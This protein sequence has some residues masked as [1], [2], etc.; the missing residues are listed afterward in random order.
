MAQLD[1]IPP[2]LATDDLPV[3][4]TLRFEDLRDALKKGLDDFWAIPTHVVFLCLI[5]P[6][7]GLLLFRVT[8]VYDLL[9]LLFPLAAGFALLGPFAAI[10]LYEISR[11]RELGMDTSWLHAFDIIHSPSLLHIV[12]LGCVLM[13]IFGAWIAVANV[14]YAANF[15]DQPLTSPFAFAN[16]V[17]TTPE[18]RSLIIAGNAAGFVFA[19][20][21]ASV[22]VVSFPLLLDRNVG[23]RVAILTS[24]KLVVKN[25]VVMATWFLIV[26]GGLLIGSL[27][28]LVGLAVVLPVLGHS[29]WHLYRR[30][31]EPDLSPRPEYHPRQKGKR[32]AA[33]FPASLFAAYRDKEGDK[34]EQ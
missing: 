10:G 7:V 17:F 30:A 25:P 15:G 3:A 34:N 11:R 19:L 27:P 12:A 18:G 9:P 2:A 33:D 23:F 21:A 28:L 5:Y 26:A 13:A 6:I 14:I 8:F 1:Y 16:Q 32:F 22:S 4:R 24:V 20:L 29:T 31:I